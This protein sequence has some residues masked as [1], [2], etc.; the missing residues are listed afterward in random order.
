MRNK[1]RIRL[2]PATT[3]LNEAKAWLKDVGAILDGIIAKRSDWAA[4][5]GFSRTMA[6]RLRKEGKGPRIVQLGDRAIGVTRKADREWTE[7]RER[8]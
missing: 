7:A 5:K 4:S 6:D 8:S 1:T 3:K 2:S